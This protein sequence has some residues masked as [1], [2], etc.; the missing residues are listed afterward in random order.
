MPYCQLC[1]KIEG[2]GHTNTAEHIA[3]IHYNNQTNQYNFCE[4]CKMG[5]ATTQALSSHNRSNMHRI[6]ELPRASIQHIPE[7]TQIENFTN[8]L[9]DNFKGVAMNHII[10]QEYNYD[11]NIRAYV[12]A[13][14]NLIVQLLNSRAA[15]ADIKYQISVNIV[16]KIERAGNTEFMTNTV[17]S[18][19]CL[20]FVTN[21]L[22][23]P[24]A[25]LLDLEN[26]LE[27]I[28]NEGESAKQFSNFSKIMLHTYN[29]IGMRGSSFIEM[30][31]ISESVINVQNTDLM[32]F[33]WAVLS[34][35][36]QPETTSTKSFQVFTFPIYSQF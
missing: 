7:G 22:Q 18:D 29:I 32:C 14:E 6:K 11:S 24:E 34:A 21:I 20:Q 17:S 1:N 12:L 15:R 19:P 26:E 25:V 33:K 30:P 31:F 5:F 28:M 2:R 36:H 3:H 16:F 23:I 10:T 35:L 9:Q 13:H 4:L 8:I 27:K